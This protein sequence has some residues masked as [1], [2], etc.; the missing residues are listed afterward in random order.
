MHMR[1]GAIGCQGVIL[2]DWVVIDIDLCKL[3]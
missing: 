1:E 2:K 3:I